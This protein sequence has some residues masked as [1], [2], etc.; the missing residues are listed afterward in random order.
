M[1]A[2]AAA[3]DAQAAE[4][5]AAKKQGSDTATVE[6]V[7]TTDIGLLSHESRFELSQN[8]NCWING[9]VAEYYGIRTVVSR[10]GSELCP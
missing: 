10:A 5:I 1:A 9:D 2:Y 3:R 8:P 7:R 6:G 4:I